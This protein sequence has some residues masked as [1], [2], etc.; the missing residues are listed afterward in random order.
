MQAGSVLR[1]RTISTVHFLGACAQ[2]AALTESILIANLPNNG[3]GGGIAAGGH[4]RSRLHELRILSVQNLA[5]AVELY[6]TPAF[7]ET[8]PTIDDEIFLGRW[9]FTSA[10][11][12]KDT[13]DDYWKYWV[14]GLDL[15]YQ[16][17][18]VSG[19]LNVRLINLSVVDKIAAA[20]GAIVLEFG[21]EPTQGM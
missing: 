7:P 21:F 4:S 11:G 9:E 10:N 13:A 8:N 2:N 6:G 19:T 12:R 3:A 20:P 18:L 5:W 15:S 17:M 16:D 14:P 1:I